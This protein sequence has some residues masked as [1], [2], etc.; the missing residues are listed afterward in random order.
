MEMYIAEKKSLGVKVANALGGGNLSNGFIDGGAWRVYFCRGHILEMLA[1]KDYNPAWEKWDGDALPM[2]P[3]EWNL[4]P[5]EDV[6]HLLELIEDGLKTASMVVNVDDADREGQLLVDEVLE[7]LNWQGTTKRLWFSDQSQT[8]IN[9]NIGK[10]EGNEKYA[11]LRNQALARSRADWVIGLNSTRAYTINARKQ[12][13]DELLSIGRVQTPTLAL[14]VNRDLAIENFVSQPFYEIMGEFKCETGYFEHETYQGKLNISDEL[15]NE[16]G[17]FTNEALANEI[18]ATLGNET[19]ATIADVQKKQKKN[20]QP[21]CFSKSDLVEQCYKEFG[22][23]GDK[24]LEIAQSLY[25]KHEATTY[26]RTDCGYLPESAHSEAPVLLNNLSTIADYKESVSN[27]DATIKAHTW[28]DSKLTAHD[29]IRPTESVNVDTYY[30][31]SQEE[32]NVFGV[33]AKRYI[34][35]FYG[36]QVIDET[37]FNTTVNEHTFTTKGA[38]II[39]RGWTVL[40]PDKKKKET[41]LP[42]VDNGNKV[43]INKIERVDKKTSPPKHFNDGNH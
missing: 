19:D 10:L 3:S 22:Y 38:V 43:T 24:V 9:K 20:K 1:P 36:E 31:M 39:D 41:T 32:K 35:Q 37:V 40:Y 8:Y 33:I 2:I 42:K 17:Y 5:K 16:H 7:Y 29:G 26:P 11:G 18:I 28:N 34:A 21:L 12:G 4:K 27:A 6:K 14:I 13:I 30:K 25:D 23:D 15:K